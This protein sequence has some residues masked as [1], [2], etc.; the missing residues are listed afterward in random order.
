M[1]R[2]FIVASLAVA[3]TAGL[4]GTGV[5]SYD[6][7]SLVTSTTDSA[8]KAP[9]AGPT[10][11]AALTATR[12]DAGPAERSAKAAKAADPS[13]PSFDIVRLDPDS[14]SVFAGKAMP[15]SIVTILA[16]GRPIATAKA[17]ETGD[18]SIVVEHPFAAGEHQLTVTA[19]LGDQGTAVQGQSVSMA[20]AKG[21]T[22]RVAEASPAKREM[23]SATSAGKGPA[24]TSA[25]AVAELE[26][27][28]VSARSGSPGQAVSLPVPITF[29]Y[30][31]PN[32]TTEG[33]RAAGLLAE[34]LRLRKLDTIVLSGHADERGSD[35]YNMELS[36]QRLESVARYLRDNGY[37]GKLTL[38]PKGKSEP[39]T[40]IDRNQLPK[41]QVFQLDRRVQLHLTR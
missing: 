13:K 7:A 36:W 12:T 37:A 25:K 32:F 39:Y 41:E 34:Y 10:R 19:K 27:M 11:T 38:L 3:T 4:V 6:F 33:V 5:L 24:P 8:A 31:E 28:V 1:S 2:I 16:N 18:W 20:V 29:V 35:Q 26:R 14:F 17:S 40:G 9:E 21:A 15:N 30:N 23:P 22:P